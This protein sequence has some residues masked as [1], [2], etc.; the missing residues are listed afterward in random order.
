MH[1]GGGRTFGRGEA[2]PPCKCEP[3]LG[4]E[5]GQPRRML[6]SLDAAA[7]AGHVDVV[8]QLV[9]QLGIENCGGAS[10]GVDTL[11]LAAQ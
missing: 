4:K 7:I 5:V 11:L 10:H 1:S 6:L 8:C 9:Q 2:S 3:V